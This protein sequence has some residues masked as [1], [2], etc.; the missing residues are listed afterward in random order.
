MRCHHPEKLRVELRLPEWCVT[1]A[2]EVM[3]E[4]D[5]RPQ[6]APTTGLWSSWSCASA[7]TVHERQAVGI[8]LPRIP[9]IEGRLYRCREFCGFKPGVAA[10]MGNARLRGRSM[11]ARS[12]FMNLLGV[13]ELV[14]ARRVPTLGSC[15]RSWSR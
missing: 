10:I 1:Q 11:M 7:V 9:G 2:P 6:R 14:V 13:D 4:L 15:G 5:V 12:F 8:A 3:H